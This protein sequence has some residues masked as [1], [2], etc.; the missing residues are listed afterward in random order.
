MLFLYINENYNKIP[1]TK[2]NVHVLIFIKIE[3]NTKR[4]Y[5][6]KS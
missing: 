1:S 4:F 3:K 6:Q 2:D 5:I